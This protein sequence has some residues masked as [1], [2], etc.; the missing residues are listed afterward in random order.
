MSLRDSIRTEQLSG[1]R[2]DKA[3]RT[4]DKQARWICFED[5][6]RVLNRYIGEPVVVWGHIGWLR[7]DDSG[8]AFE[9]NSWERQ[10]NFA[11]I[12]ASEYSN[13]CTGQLHK[14]DFFVRYPGGQVQ[15][16]H[17]TPTYY[18]YGILGEWSSDLVNQY[19]A[20]VP[21]PSIDAEFVK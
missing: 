1:R 12:F 14:C 4:F 6:K 21:M 7:E 19:G 13:K 11:S 9:L 18:V 20:P 3:L 2:L 16:H 5:I 8:T 10:K 17:G 15:F